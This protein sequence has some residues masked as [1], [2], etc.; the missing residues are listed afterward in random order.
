MYSNTRVRL[1]GLFRPG[2]TLLNAP[3]DKEA[4]HPRR[5]AGVADE[6]DRK[7]PALF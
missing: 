7:M 6:R 1:L 4:V 5:G 2:G 3:R